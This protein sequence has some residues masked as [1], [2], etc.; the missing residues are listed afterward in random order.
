M[1]TQVASIENTP[2]NSYTRRR[3]AAGAGTTCANC[4]GYGKHF[5]IIMR[6]KCS[7]PQYLCI[8]KRKTKKR[9]G[10]NTLCV[11]HSGV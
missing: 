1:L 5:G 3:R 4:S 8:E 6:H 10:E 2:I 7:L 11:S 9:K